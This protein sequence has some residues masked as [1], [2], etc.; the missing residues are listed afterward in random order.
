MRDYIAAA[1]AQKIPFAL[2]LFVGGL[3]RVYICPNRYER[4]LGVPDTSLDSRTFA[5]DGDLHHNQ[6]LSGEIDNSTHNLITNATNVPE[7]ATINTALAA[8]IPPVPNQLMLGPYN[9]W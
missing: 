5:F 9:K 1:G 4:A 2:G 6:G 3:F 8:L 7:V